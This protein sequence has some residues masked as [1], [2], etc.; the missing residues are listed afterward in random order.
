MAGRRSVRVALAVFAAQLRDRPLRLVVAVGA[1]ALGVA[2]AAGVYLVNESAL[3]E[4]A[5]ATRQLVGDADLVVRG[6]RGG[7]AEELYPRLATRPEVAVA[8]PVV[9]VEVSLAAGGTLPVLG[10]DP[11]LAGALQPALY[12]DLVGNFVALLGPDA[13]ALSAP[14]AGSLGLAPGGTLAVRIGAERAH[15]QGR[16]GAA[17]V[18]LRA[19]ARRHGHRL[20]AVDARHARPA[21]ADRPAA[22]AR[23][24]CGALSARAWNSPPASTS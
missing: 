14:A 3:A 15:A 16:R 17:R 8:S 10:V 12:G 20:G 7:F 21:R 4:F 9:E 5:R 19:P 22:A 2:L 11:L 24:R 18:G 13:I 1:I 23:R 6:G